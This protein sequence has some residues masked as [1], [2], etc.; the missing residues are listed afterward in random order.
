MGLRGIFHIHATVYPSVGNLGFVC[1]YIANVTFVGAKQGPGY[2]FMSY[3]S[4]VFIISANRRE[5][6]FAVAE[7][8]CMSFFST[9]L[10]IVFLKFSLDSILLQFLC[11]MPLCEYALCTVEPH[12][13]LI[14]IAST[15]LVGRQK[16][17]VGVLSMTNCKSF[18]IFFNRICR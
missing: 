1:V 10:F 7:Y 8:L 2:L 11:L 17:N 9:H 14:L 5:A 12:D 13:V 6:T 16:I 4:V 18:G 3:A 15:K